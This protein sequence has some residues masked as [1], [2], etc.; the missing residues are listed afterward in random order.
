MTD[1]Q[2]TGEMV[3][4]LREA[5]GLSREELASRLGISLATLYRLESR[6]VISKSYSRHL[7]ALTGE[8]RSVEPDA[9]LSREIAQLATVAQSRVKVVEAEEL[10]CAT[11]TK[12]LSA[13]EIR[14][15]AN[16]GTGEDVETR[17]QAETMEYL[18]KFFVRVPFARNVFALYQYVIDPK[19][20]LLSKSLALGA[21][22]Y[23]ISQVDMIPDYIPVAG[24]LDDAAIIASVVAHY[25]DKLKPYLG[26]FDE[27]KRT[28][29]L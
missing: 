20:D 3:K 13:D 5:K 6:A 29:G 2:W 22:L 28:E 15:I 21:L 17:V 27:W 14:R 16:V 4:N 24:F 11:V 7:D 26:R 10:S 18:K 8:S 19:R 9:A 12:P 1:T 23:F 25:H